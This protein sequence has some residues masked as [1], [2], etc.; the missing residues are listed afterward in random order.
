[1]SKI[2]YMVPL[3]IP[4]ANKISNVVWTLLEVVRYLHILHGL[5]L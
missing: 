4:S 5:H 2:V 1:M 3:E